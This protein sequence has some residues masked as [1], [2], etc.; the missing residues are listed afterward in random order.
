MSERT[1]VDDEEIL[2][3]EKMITEHECKQQYPVPFDVEEFK[4][5]PADI[6]SFFENISSP[7]SKDMFEQEVSQDTKEN[8]CLDFSNNKWREIGYVIISSIVASS[9]VIKMFR[10]KF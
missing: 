1:E 7:E 8:Y 9:L 10:R 2:T 6:M 4:Y 3:I 5:E